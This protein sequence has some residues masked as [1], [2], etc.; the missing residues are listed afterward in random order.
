MGVLDDAPDGVDRLVTAY[1]HAVGLIAYKG[2]RV[3]AN[4]SRRHLTHY[5]K[6]ILNSAPF[7]NRLTQIKNAAE[8][9][10]I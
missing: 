9:A 1:R 3:G 8:A 2:E 6:G 10:E 5:T 7:R 4:E